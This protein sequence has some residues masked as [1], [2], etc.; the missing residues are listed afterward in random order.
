MITKLTR[1]ALAA[2]FVRMANVHASPN[3]EYSV[4]WTVRSLSP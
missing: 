4:V 2:T 1:T 3:A